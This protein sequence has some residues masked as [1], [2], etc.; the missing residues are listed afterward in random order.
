M[1]TSLFDRLICN[2]VNE[3]EL[4]GADVKKITHGDD[5]FVIMTKQ[6]KLYTVFVDDQSLPY[7][8]AQPN[9]INDLNIKDVA[10]GGQH[11]VVL[12]SDNKIHTWGSNGDGQ[13]RYTGQCE[14]IEFDKQITTIA[15][16][17]YYTACS[18]IDGTVHVWGDNS[19]GQCDYNINDVRSIHAGGE[20]NV[21]CIKN[22]NTLVSWGNK[23]PNYTIS[24]I[25]TFN[26]G[27]YH[28][29]AIDK[30]NSL[31][32]LGRSLTTELD[33]P[34]IDQIKQI[35]VNGEL[36]GHTFILQ[37]DGTM[38]GLGNNTFG[39]ISP[40]LPHCNDI[41]TIVP[42]KWKYISTGLTWSVGVTKNDELLGWGVFR[43]D[44]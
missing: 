34:N 17:T 13:Q 1:Y 25:E 28:H 41:N 15:A 23:E 36:P 19:D 39:Q 27:H 38:Y 42:G 16:G 31:I 6:N 5:H 8:L 3:L 24:D 37:H 32:P 12:T 33:L 2:R 43:G 4:T 21:Y 18:F 9:Y 11:V 22:D 29:I 35:C 14:C 30:T 44:Y 10:A 20:G 26:G 7:T 40:E